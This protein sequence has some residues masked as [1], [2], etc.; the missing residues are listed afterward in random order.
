MGAVITVLPCVSTN[1]SGDDDANARPKSTA[2]IYP[3]NGAGLLVAKRWKIAA[4][5]SSSIP[6]QVLPKFSWYISP[7]VIESLIR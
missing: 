5:S 1:I 7:D 6:P 2:S 3:L 4:G